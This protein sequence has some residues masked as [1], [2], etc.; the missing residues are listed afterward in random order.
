MKK[1]SLMMSLLFVLYQAGIA[2]WTTKWTYT[3]PTSNY[4]IA[5][6]IKN[7]DGDP[8]PEIVIVTPG[9]T[10]PNT[11]YV[12]DGSTGMVEYTYGPKYGIGI[13]AIEDL[14][15]DGRNEILLDVHEVINTPSNLVV[16]EYSGGTYV[17]SSIG[18]PSAPD[19]K[20]N[21]P[22]PFNPSTTIQYEVP[23]LDRI[24]L[25]I[26][27]SAGQVVRTL[28]DEHKDAG[29]YTVLWDGKND[30]GGV[31]SSGAYFYQLYGKNFSQAKKMLLVK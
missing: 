30:R 27:N 17:E 25:V 10:T 18:M 7:L 14:D 8:Q 31:V 26:C 13:I 28:L 5:P 16:L 15:T 20:Q 2:Q 23:T 3:V 29:I 1:V 24:T 4:R 6:E 22:N 19:L 11:L 9:S 12:I 21:F